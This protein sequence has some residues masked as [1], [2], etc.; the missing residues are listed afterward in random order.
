MQRIFC[1][2][3]SKSLTTA[4]LG[5]AI[6]T[7]ACQS[8]NG[9]QHY[10]KLFKN[11]PEKPFLWKLTDNKQDIYL[12]GTIHQGYNPQ[13]VPNIVYKILASSQT[14][15]ME[16][17]LRKINVSE[18][19]TI[20]FY[21]DNESLKEIIGLETFKKLEYLLPHL[22]HDHLNKMK[23]ST[24]YSQLLTTLVPSNGSIDE[25]IAKQV[26]DS[27]K[28]LVALETPSLQ[29]QLLANIITPE[30]LTQFINLIDDHFIKQAKEMLFKTF[31]YYKTAEPDLLIKS[32]NES[33]MSDLKLSDEQLDQLIFNRNQNW[34]KKIKSL[35]S[36]D[37][38]FIAVGAAHLG[39]PKGLLKLFEAEKYTIQPI[40]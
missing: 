18:W 40:E 24:V 13:N 35:V 22:P 4:W 36:N 9:N 27:G 23:P 10:E 7:I 1:L 28:K 3:L 30:K 2:L 17:D 15:I 20:S 31:Y 26:Y 37:P 38:I 39:G 25:F 6:L 8:T 12:F 34:L 33:T 19:R 16:I 32:I 14:V 5:L 29:T 21:E 11:A